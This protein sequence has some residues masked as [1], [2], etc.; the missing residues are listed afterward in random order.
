[1]YIHHDYVPATWEKICTI[2]AIASRYVFDFYATAHME[3][4]LY[5]HT[6]THTQITFAI[7][8]FSYFAK[9]IHPVNSHT[10]DSAL[11]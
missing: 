2:Y 8:V 10:T 9:H 4:S 1:M 5:T 11:L 3:K 7:N 6:H